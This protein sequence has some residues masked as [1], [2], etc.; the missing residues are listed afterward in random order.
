MRAWEEGRSGSG[1][2]PTS[3][4]LSGR[5]LHPRPPARR[6]EGPPP[7]PTEPTY[8]TTG[9]ATRRPA[10]SYSRRYGAGFAASTPPRQ[11]PGGQQARRLAVAPPRLGAASSEPTARDA[12]AE[13]PGRGRADVLGCCGSAGASV[14]RN[15]SALTVLFLTKVR[16][17]D[18]AQPP[19][20]DAHVLV[21]A[22]EGKGAV[23]VRR[24]RLGLASG[25]AAFRPG[26]TWRVIGLDRDRALDWP[27]AQ[28]EDRAH[29]L[30]LE[31]RLA[32]PL[33]ARLEQNVL[34]AGPAQ[35]TG[36]WASRDDMFRRHPQ[37]HRPQLLGLTNAAIDLCHQVRA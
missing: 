4:G 23:E 18:L 3:C 19:W 1:L 17:S 5:H 6:A 15:P 26:G 14:A 31:P 30:G 37:S 36:R 35:L 27:E 16:W 22:Q 25:A 12:S 10:A 7:P 13:R 24:W 20:H 29:R 8:V 9:A 33:R 2:K 34:A 28:L 21:A 11:G 32:L